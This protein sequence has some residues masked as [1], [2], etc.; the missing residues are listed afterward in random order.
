VKKTYLLALLFL[1]A[2][3]LP[4]R[5][6]FAL[7]TRVTVELPGQPYVLNP[8]K[9]R[10][11]KHP[12]HMKIWWLRTL[13]GMYLLY[14]TL[15]PKL[16][17]AADDTVSRSLHYERVQTILK[18]EHAQGIVARP[19]LVA[20]IEG[21]DFTYKSFRRSTGKIETRYMRS[22][23]L[24]SVS[25]VLLFIPTSQV[26]IIGYASDSQRRRFFNSMTVKP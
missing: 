11:V 23:L 22:L 14:R 25:Y 18:S 10:T 2:C 16:H 24:D 21:R 4:H 12:E 19:F 9:V 13:G 17:I 1:A 20:G 8:N 15:N 7:D 6:Q 3:K 26:G 5:Q